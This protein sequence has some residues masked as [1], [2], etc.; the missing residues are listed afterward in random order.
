MTPDYQTVM[1]EIWDNDGGEMDAKLAELDTRYNEAF[2]AAVA[3]GTLV[4]EDFTIPEFDPLTW[5]PS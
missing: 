4:A 5:T 1:Q 2:A 3:D